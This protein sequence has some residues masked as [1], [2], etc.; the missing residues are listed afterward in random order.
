ML[1][2]QQLIY[3]DIHITI[4]SKLDAKYKL[5]KKDSAKSE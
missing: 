1:Y 5:A 3:N 4:F 2:A